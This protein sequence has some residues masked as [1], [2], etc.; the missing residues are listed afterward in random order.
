M[1]EE[2][3]FDE[4]KGKKC[5]ARL[6]V[7]VGVIL[8]ATISAAILSLQLTYAQN[9][10]ATNK[11]SNNRINFELGNKAYT[12]KYQ[13][14]GGNLTGISAEKDNITLLLNVSST[15]NGKLNIELPR[16]ILDSKK[17]GNVDDNF[18]VFVDGQYAAADEIKTTAQVRTLMVDFDNG[19]SVIEITGT[20]MVPEF[21]T[22]VIA[23][24]AISI[25]GVILASS[26]YNGIATKRL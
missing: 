4:I 17:Q 14:I 3:Q 23:I 18:A 15:S 26:K 10:T 21:S 8:L 13:I 11:A 20:Q 25:I 19:T 2:R 1:T 7:V 5:D 22:V 6:P 12:I 9:T 16:N 24:F